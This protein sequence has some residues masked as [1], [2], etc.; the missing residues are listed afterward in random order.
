ML[1]P[2][3]AQHVNN[4]SSREESRRDFVK[5]A[6]YIAPAILTLPAAPE[7]AKAG[8]VKPGGGTERPPKASPPG[9][10]KGPKG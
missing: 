3:E 6:A 7:Y 5:R 4:M 2:K 8:S 10:G 9:K 1:V